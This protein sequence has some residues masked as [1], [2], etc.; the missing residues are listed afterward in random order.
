MMFDPLYLWFALPGLLLALWASWRVRAT[1]ARY[2]RVGTRSGAT[3]EWV[4]RALLDAHGLRDLPIEEIPGELSDHYDPRARVLR[5]STAVYRGSSVAAVG[6]AAHEAGHALQHAANYLPLAVRGGI[7]PIAMVGP[8]LAWILFVVGL[9]AHWPVLA[10]IAILIYLGVVFFALVTLPVEL[11]AS[12]RA[13]SLLG[14]VGVLEADELPAA[15]KVLTAAALTY[16][17]AAIQA[18]LMLLYMFLRRR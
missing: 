3:G 10:N 9:A 4:A 14:S 7:A 5:L 18:I 2:S 15:R 16:V 17:A 13:M 11:N 8:H 6:V 12:K 1:Y